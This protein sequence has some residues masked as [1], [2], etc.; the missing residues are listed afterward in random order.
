MD[1]K[2]PSNFSSTGGLIRA[3]SNA[4][5][6]R[7]RASTDIID[8]HRTIVNQRGIDFSDFGGAFIWSHDTFKG[9][10]G[11]T[12]E[13]KNQLGKVV[14]REITEFDREVDGDKAT[15]KGLAT[16]IDVRFSKVNPFAVMAEGMVREG[17]LGMTS[18]GFIPKKDHA[19]T[20]G[21][22]VI[23]VFDEIDLLE[24]SLVPVPANP[25]AQ[26]LVRSMYGYLE[27][28]APAEFGV[29]VRQTHE[30]S[31]A[32]QDD[33]GWSFR[34]PA[35]EKPLADILGIRPQDRDYFPWKG[36]G[37]VPPNVSAAK[38]EEGTPWSRPSLGDF[39]S[40]TWGEL[41][42]RERKRIIGHFA[43]APSSNTD[44]F[45]FSDLKLPHHRA[46]DAK[47]VFRGVS[48]AMGALLGARGGVDI[49]G[50]DRR[51]VYNH[52]A[53][54][55]RVFDRVPPEFRMSS[56]PPLDGADIGSARDIVGGAMRDWIDEQRALRG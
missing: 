41:T 13:I 42:V 17:I 53:A 5:I 34:S 24:I 25:E 26:A 55:Y 3:A 33:M 20:V 39:T 15:E 45:V 49:P 9:M 2:R 51:A 14:G 35:M 12:P 29:Q 4:P 21:E 38:A 6:L 23:K 32:W 8:R 50:G 18:I 11:G 37:I 7:F 27:K 54:H 56:E 47:I 19:L 40:K 1:K 46:S 52:L 30:G 36:L 48:A 28:E 16:D 43:W 22:E 31:W 10:F 44:E